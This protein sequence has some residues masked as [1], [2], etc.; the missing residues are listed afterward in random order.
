M[1]IVDIVDLDRD[2]RVDSCLDVIFGLMRRTATAA[3]YTWAGRND[4][5]GQ[6]RA[7]AS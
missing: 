4:R 7:R 2:I 3:T 6:E 5:L 1:H